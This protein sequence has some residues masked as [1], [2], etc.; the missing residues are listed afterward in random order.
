M[1]GSISL[2]KGNSAI[3]ERLSLV[4]QEMSQGRGLS[5][6]LRTCNYDGRFVSI[7]KLI[8]SYISINIENTRD[9][10]VAEKMENYIR[11]NQDIFNG[12]TNKVN[13]Q[14]C[15]TILEQL[16]KHS[17]S[18]NAK[19]YDSCLTLL[20]NQEQTFSSAPTAT[21]KNEDQDPKSTD[22]AE[23]SWPT[24]ISKNDKPAPLKPTQ[25]PS[26]TISADFSKISQTKLWQDIK[27]HMSNNGYLFNE[28]IKLI[29]ARLIQGVQDSS[30]E[31]VSSCL[32]TI[33]HLKAVNQNPLIMQGAKKAIELNKVEFFEEFDKVFSETFPKWILNSED[34]DIM[35]ELWDQTIQYKSDH[36]LNYLINNNH[37]TYYRTAL[38]PVNILYG[39]IYKFN[40][41]AFKYVAEP[42]LRKNADLLKISPKETLAVALA[43]Y[44]KREHLIWL[45]TNF[46]DIPLVDADGI[47]ALMFAIE[48]KDA[49]LAE[50]LI[51][52]DKNGL[53]W[54]GA[55]DCG[56]NGVTE[57]DTQEE[58]LVKMKKQLG[59]N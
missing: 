13:R 29:Q 20:S 9:R 18:K 15:T 44:E 8:L 21:V 17:K 39:L 57:A 1:S 41:E 54:K 53:A 3:P 31:T 30:I 49:E 59:V 11:S 43:T 51:K 5:S 28:G 6:K 50:L 36:I 55:A 24:V 19:Y 56:I 40:F 25:E 38:G 22:I 45:L 10:V 48:D 27:P 35:K 32:D 37:F 4:A 16:K 14:N 34:E 7:I 2:L 12:P 58:V 26:T 46:E 47:N 33:Q 52:K 42:I 23:D